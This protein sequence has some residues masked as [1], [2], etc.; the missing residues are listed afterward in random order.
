VKISKQ[1]NGVETVPAKYNTET[2]LG[3]E[4]AGDV[5]SIIQGVNYKMTSP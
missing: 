3:Q 4:V 2:T 5:P 1:V